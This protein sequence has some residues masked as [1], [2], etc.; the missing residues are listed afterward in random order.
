MKIIRIRDITWNTDYFYAELVLENFWGKRS[1]KEIFA[2]KFTDG[3]AT[4]KYSDTGEIVH[5]Y[6][7]S[8]INA[9]VMKKYYLKNV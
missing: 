5:P 2:K 6:L 7:N 3:Y 8:A 9:E 4:Y 1:N